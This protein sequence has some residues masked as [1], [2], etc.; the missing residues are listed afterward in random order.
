MKPWEENYGPKTDAAKPWDAQYDATP[1]K[2]TL[3]QAQR[4]RQQDKNVFGGL[5]RGAGSIGSTILYPYDRIKGGG[6]EGGLKLN[7]ERRAAIDAGTQELFGSDPN[8]AGYATGKIGTEILGT[9]G[10]GGLVA[11]GVPYL[12]QSPTAAKFANTLRS[13]GFSTGAPAATT[14]AGKAADM[15]IR[16]L[17]GGLSAGAMTGMIDPQNAGTGALIGA[18]LPP[19]LKAAAQTGGAVRRLVSG[20]A[21]AEPVRKAVESARGAGYVIPPTQAKPTLTNR[22]LEG[23]S[24]KITTAQNASARNQPVTQKL[25]AKELGLPDGTPVSLDT[26]KNIRQQAGDAYNAVKAVGVIT[27]GPSYAKKLDDIVEPA[28]LAAAGFPNAKVNPIIAEI[29][30]LKS[31]QFDASSAVAKIRELRNSADTAYAAGNKELGKAYKQASAALEDAIEDHLT[32]INAPQDLL[33]GFRDARQMIAKTYS[34]E[35]AMNVTTGN[36]DAVKLGQQL[37]KGKPLSGGIRDV[38]AF[39]QQFPKAAQT[40]ERMGSLP[41]SSPLDW[42]ASGVASA[43]TANPAM[44]A[45]LLVRPAARNAALSKWVQDN[46]ANPQTQSQMMGLLSDPGLQ[47]MLYRSTPVMATSANR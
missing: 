27:P 3:T 43:A 28:K 13:G 23:L 14:F 45:G 6:R 15:G 16:S 41:Q 11:K 21:V 30:A 36:V 1:S 19:S 44:M 24:G 4:V 8:S 39:G 25:I 20:P 29:D 42:A 32:A 18:A 22:F 17:G 26:L 10:A 35:K 34:V 46:L 9:A 2:P 31:P 7:R 40:V 5:I 47:Q 12:S 38:A 37:A 33:K